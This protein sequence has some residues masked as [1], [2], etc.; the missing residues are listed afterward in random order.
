M[1]LNNGD[2]RCT[3]VYGMSDKYIA[4][5]QFIVLGSKAL[6][7]WLLLW[8]GFGTASPAAAGGRTPFWIKQYLS[9]NLF[10]IIEIVIFLDIRR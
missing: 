6:S 4:S 7:F 9:L 3:G 5:A 2:G 1:T 10:A 8:L